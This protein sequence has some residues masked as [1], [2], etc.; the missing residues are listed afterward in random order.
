MTYQKRFT[1]DTNF[2]TNIENY[3]FFFI[4]NHKGIKLKRDIKKA[5]GD[6][7]HVQ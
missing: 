7:K 3:L 5:S 2:K 4:K 1:I 6:A